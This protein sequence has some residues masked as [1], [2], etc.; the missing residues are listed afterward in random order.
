MRGK[1]RIENDCLY[2][3]VNRWNRYILR[4]FVIKILAETF[5]EDRT[6]KLN[7]VVKKVMLVK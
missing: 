1:Y 6:D 3:I 5:L 4:A 7:F 2:V